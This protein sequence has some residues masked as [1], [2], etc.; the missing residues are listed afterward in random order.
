MKPASTPYYG[1]RQAHGYTRVH[2]ARERAKSANAPSMWAPKRAKHAS[3]QFGRL[4]R[5]WDE[6][7]V[8]ELFLQT[9]LEKIFGKN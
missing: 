9:M 3:T 2:G 7:W 4:N 6:L 5:D 8:K 1:A